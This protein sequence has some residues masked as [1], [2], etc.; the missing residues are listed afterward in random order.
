MPLY[1]L[2][3]DEVL[4][5]CCQWNQSSKD[6]SGERPPDFGRDFLDR[7]AGGIR[8]HASVAGEYEHPVPVRAGACVVCPTEARARE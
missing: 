6:S 1:E 3:W 7:S 4:G 2:G 8:D 5:G